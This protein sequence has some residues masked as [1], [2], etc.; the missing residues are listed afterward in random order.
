MRSGFFFS[1]I[2]FDEKNAKFLGWLP[3]KFKWKFV[4]IFAG[5]RSDG[6]RWWQKSRLARKI[7]LDYRLKCG[8]HISTKVSQFSSPCT[9]ESLCFLCF[10]KDRFL[11]SHMPMMFASLQNKHVSS[12]LPMREALPTSSTSYHEPTHCCMT[13]GTCNGHNM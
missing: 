11:L 4:Q 10:G 8:I 13:L 12:A 3:S 1:F 6:R 7:D 2:P 5:G 9:L